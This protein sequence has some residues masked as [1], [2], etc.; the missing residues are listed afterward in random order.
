MQ[1]SDHLPNPKTTKLLFK[2]CVGNVKQFVR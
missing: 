1:L 2:K